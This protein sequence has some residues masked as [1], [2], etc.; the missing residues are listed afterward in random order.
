MAGIDVTGI[1][2]VLW[3]AGAVTGVYSDIRLPEFSYAYVSALVREAGAWQSAAQRLI[4]AT[5]T[6]SLDRLGAGSYR[7]CAFDYWQVPF[8]HPSVCYVDIISSPDYAQAVT[9]TGNVT[10]SGIDL[11]AGA[12]GDGATIGGL[13]RGAGGAPLAD[14]RVTLESWSIRPPALSAQR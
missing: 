10:T 12:E 6:Y 9:V 13:V 1:D 5:G 14:I 2:V 7:I 4:L 3:P 11:N 8:S